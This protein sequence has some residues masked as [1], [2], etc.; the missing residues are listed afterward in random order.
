[1]RGATQEVVCD[2]LTVIVSIHA[3]HAG[4]DLSIYYTIGDVMCFN[5]RAPCG[6]RRE[7]YRGRFGIGVFQSTRPMRGAT[8]RAL[9]LP[10]RARVSIHAPHAGRDS[11]KEDVIDQ[12][13]VSIHAPHAGRDGNPV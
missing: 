1:M 9:R 11:F 2:D 7:V 6:A 5:P 4:R 3:P 12:I 10:R 8:A 13:V